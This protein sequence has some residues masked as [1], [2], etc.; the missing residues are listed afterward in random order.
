MTR[1]KYANDV[2]ISRVLPRAS[3]SKLK[4]GSA[5]GLRCMS[6]KTSTHIDFNFRQ[7]AFMNGCASRWSTAHRSALLGGPRSWSMVAIMLGMA[8]FSPARFPTCEPDVTTMNTFLRAFRRI[9]HAPT[10][11]K[12]ATEPVTSFVCRNIST[13]WSGRL[14]STSAAPAYTSRSTTCVD[15]GAER[16][17]FLGF[18]WLLRFTRRT[19]LRE[20]RRR[21]CSPGR[22]FCSKRGG[23]LGGLEDIVGSSS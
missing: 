1:Q 21:F 11:L 5:H 4:K 9:C 16:N 20:R 23:N 3:I 7:K 8:N 14:L 13:L 18:I 17:L 15:L 12:S 10:V 19:G 2:Q 6:F 22:P